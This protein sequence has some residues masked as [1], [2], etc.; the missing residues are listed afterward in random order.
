MTNPKIYHV[1]NSCG[2][3][4]PVSIPVELEQS[5]RNLNNSYL[6]DGEKGVPYSVFISWIKSVVPDGK[7]IK[8]EVHNFDDPKNLKFKIE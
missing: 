3:F 8:A 6:L 7:T 5:F 2:D 4:T 1:V